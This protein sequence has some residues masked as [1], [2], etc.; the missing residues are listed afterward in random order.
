LFYFHNRTIDLTGTTLVQVLSTTDGDN[1]TRL[2]GGSALT[3]SKYGSLV[4]V[5]TTCDETAFPGA[6]IA[7]SQAG[8]DAV[9]SYLIDGLPSKQQVR[10]ALPGSVRS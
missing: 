4:V 1:L 10:L 3:D 5:T 6:T 8:V 9:T 7:S 2:A